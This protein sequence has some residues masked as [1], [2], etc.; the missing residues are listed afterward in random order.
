MKKFIALLVTMLMIVTSCSAGKYVSLNNPEREFSAVE[1]LYNQHP[2]LVPYYEA[3]V[4]KI[5]S[6]R[7]IQS[8]VGYTYDIRYKFVRKYLYGDERYLCLKELYPELYDLYANGVI[9]IRTVYRYVDNKGSIQYHITYSRLYDYYYESVPLIHPYRGYRLHYRPRPIPPRM[10]PPPPRPRPEG[11][12]PPPQ[13]RPNDNHKPQGGNRPDARP[14]N[15]PRQGGG[16]QPSA[17]P[18]SQPRQ[19]GSSVRPNNPPR[20][21]GGSSVRQSNPP[22]QSGGSSRSSGG[23]RSSGGNRSGG[24]R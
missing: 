17:R 18:N 1:V 12:N 23:A 24:R 16:N 11:H 14:N 5:T 6:M 19:G 4:L 22:R 15:P 8:E 13:A 20:Q 7:E 9:N 10:T 2:E 3:G 21:S